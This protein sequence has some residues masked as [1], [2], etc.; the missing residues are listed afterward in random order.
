MSQIQSPELL[1]Q[2]QQWR[3]KSIAG[4]ITLDEMREAIKAL[5]SNRTSAQDAAKSSTAGK[6]GSKS[7][8]VDAGSLLKE[9][10]GL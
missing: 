10:D 9:L 7:T 2:L 4:T 1:N 8:P 5:R 3:A 6:R